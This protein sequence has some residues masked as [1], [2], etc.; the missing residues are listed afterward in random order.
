MIIHK[1][2][3][4]VHMESLTQSVA[5][6]YKKLLIH[7]DQD[8]LREEVNNRLLQTMKQSPTEVEYKQNLMR[9]IALHGESTKA[10]HGIL[11][12]LL[13]N[14]KYP[15]LEGVSKLINLAQ[16]RIE[17]EMDTLLTQYKEQLEKE[18]SPNDAVT[19]LEMY[20]TTTLVELRLT[21]RFIDAFGTESNRALFEHLFSYPSEEVGE[22]ILKYSRTYS[23][24]LFEKTLSQ[25]K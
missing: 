23:S 9:A 20:F 22:T 15:D 17:K 7:L 4:I 24:L 5:T 8:E 18:D 11:H 19:Q 25:Q 6:I 3:G 21:Y 13:S 1:K 2:E 12:P 10:L 16:A 14:S